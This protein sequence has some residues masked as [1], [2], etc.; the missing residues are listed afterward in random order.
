MIL[1]NSDGNAALIKTALQLVC[2]VIIINC[3]ISAQPR[4]QEDDLTIERDIQSDKEAFYGRRGMKV[5]SGTSGI[6]IVG[7]GEYVMIGT[8]KIDPGAKL[9]LNPG[10]RVF[11]ENDASLQIEG[12]LVAKGESRKKVYI[13]G[14]PAADHYLP[15]VG[16]Q[17][18]WKGIVV[19]EGAGITLSNTEISDC[20]KSIVISDRCKR[21]ALDCV[22]FKNTGAY[23]L[24]FNG[25]PVVFDNDKCAVFSFNTQKNGG[26][27]EKPFVTSAVDDSRKKRSPVKII[28]VSLF[29]AAAA[30]CFIAGTI[31]H[32]KAKDLDEKAAETMSPH[33]QKYWDD[34]NKK[35]RQR[36]VLWSIAG[37][38][39]ACGIVFTFVIPSGN[40]K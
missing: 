28:A 13:S 11:C 7:P 34:R 22:A 23:H 17:S 4:S 3:T 1:K 15:P 38:S 27:S 21:I 19:N 12:E 10:A 25:R 20:K 39:A 2:A 30:G 5:L 40:G 9:V 24:F 6:R 29:G 14:L 26:S 31:M 16:G 18:L 33:A 8:C 35:I 32:A 36:N 37:G